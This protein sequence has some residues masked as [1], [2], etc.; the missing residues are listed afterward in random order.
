[1]KLKFLTLLFV[2]LLLVSCYGQSEP[3]KKEFR[4]VWI[5]SVTNLD[6]PSNQHLS[7]AAQQQELID[8]FDQLKDL[9]FNAVKKTEKIGH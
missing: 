6:W 2:L 7:T 3:P 9:G 1:M 4:A 5:A 8:Q